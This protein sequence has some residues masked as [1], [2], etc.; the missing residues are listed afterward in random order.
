MI[1]VG[2]KFYVRGLSAGNEITTGRKK[3]PQTSFIDWNGREKTPLR[4]I[5]TREFLI[6]FKNPY[7]VMNY[8]ITLIFPIIILFVTIFLPN[9]EYGD[10]TQF[11]E[12]GKTLNLNF[13][14]LSGS[15]LLAIVS[16]TSMFVSSVGISREG[17][18]FWISKIIPL[19][20]R[21]QMLAKI[22]FSWF[23]AQ[24]LII[25][26]IVLVYLNFYPH[27]MNLLLV[28]FIASA[29]TIPI[30]A[31]GLFIDL[32]APNL[33]WTDPHR[34]VRGNLRPLL[35]FFVNLSWISV[36]G[37]GLYRIF[38]LTSDAIVPLILLLC[39]LLALVC[40]SVIVLLRLAD[41]YYPRIEA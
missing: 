35:T 24:F 21:V 39:S 16:Y 22:C 40:S 1:L 41:Y 30:V 9:E 19:S 33:R 37:Y 28:F 11:L 23:T 14:L 15:V 13:S 31:V 18:R 6:F 12:R 17:R 38:L 10:I 29:G 20:P 27:P 2:Q 5:F 26:G 7:F 32:I 25:C 4:V 36:M 34:L 3:I 8:A